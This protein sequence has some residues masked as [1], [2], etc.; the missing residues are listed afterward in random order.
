MHVRKFEAETLEQALK[1]I[2]RE[3]GPD[4]IILKTISNAGI[5]GAFKKSKIE[6]TAAISEKNY[7]KKARVDTVLD[8][9]QKDSFYGNQAGHISNMI[10]RHDESHKASHQ[11]MTQGYG[12]AALNRT[13]KTT[14][15]KIK[16]GLDDFL[17]LGT[18]EQAKPAKASNYNEET[19]EFEVAMASAA[20]QE[21]TYTEKKIEQPSPV[22]Q[23]QLPSQAYDDGKVEELEKRLWELSRSVE[24]IERK[25]PEGIYQLR[26]ILRS[27]DVSDTAIQEIIR[28]AMFELSKDE[29][30]D[31]DTVLEYALRLMVDDIKTGMPLFS[32]AEGSEK[33]VVTVLISESS[34]GQ[35][36]MARKISALKEGSVLVRCSESEDQPFTERVLGITVQNA[37][38]VPDII[39]QTR[40]AIEANKN[41]FI[42]FRNSSE[43]VQEVKRFVDGLRRSFDKVEVL[44]S[45]SAIHAEIYNRKIAARYQGIANGAV[46]SHLDLCLNFGAIYNVARDYKTM[47]LKFF[48]TGEVV[49]DDIESA[50]AERILAG[51]FQLESE[52]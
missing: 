40:K 20:P 19:D 7:T 45:L 25:E 43:E 22:V 30:Q 14:V 49:P 24:R 27:L 50:T 10:D 8:Q 31:P 21:K 48:G 44:V 36:S 46:V 12:K 13:V 39:G 51:M 11:G 34:C 32:T 2:K 23:D 3:L 38:G 4:A 26:T 9:G 41:V 42:D 35:S 5:K 18:N 15:D 52:A 37:K 6:I 1:D 47:P 16:G 28:G 29:T 17:S 33:P